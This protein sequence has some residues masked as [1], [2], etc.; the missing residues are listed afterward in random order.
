MKITKRALSMLLVLVMLLS[1]LPTTFAAD[2]PTADILN[3]D[4]STQTNTDASPN[5]LSATHRGAGKMEYVWDEEMGKYVAQF[6]GS[7]GLAYPFSDQYNKIKGGFTFE[8]T[9][10]YIS[11]PDSG[12]HD[13]L[14]NQQAGGFGLGV[15]KGN[16]T[17]FLSIGS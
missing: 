6:D 10:R 14:S 8:V 3:V 7:C 4:F 9:A 16:W 15:N 17:F 1:M 2:V 13:L 11:L 5:N 12:E